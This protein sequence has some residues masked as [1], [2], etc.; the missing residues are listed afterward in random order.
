MPNVGVVVRNLSAAAPDIVDRAESACQEVYRAA[1]IRVTWHNSVDPVTWQGP[2][3][4]LRAVILP[5][6]PLSRSTAA[7]GTALRQRQELLLYYDRIT[8]FGKIVNLPEHIM[9]S[10]ALVH[11]IGHLL[12]DSDNHASSGIMRGEWG[13]DDLN[14][15]RQGQ[16]HFT[17]DQ[18]LRIKANIE[19][20]SA[21]SR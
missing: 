15:I 4:V 19:R 13:Q 9:L 3:I 5:Q 18:I 2:D 20:G 11:E 8:R 17:S 14:A 1:G 12:L 7:F 6:A 21:R 16:L 10:I